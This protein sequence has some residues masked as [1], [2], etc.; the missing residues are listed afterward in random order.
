M[1]IYL[2]PAQAPAALR[3]SY[4]GKKFAEHMIAD[5]AEEAA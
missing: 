2:E 4:N 1:T 5:Y 3:G